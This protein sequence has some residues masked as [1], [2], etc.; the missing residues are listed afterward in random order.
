M[1]NL[2]VI[3]SSNELLTIA[4]RFVLDKSI[5]IKDI[6]KAIIIV[7]K[8]LDRTIKQITTAANNCNA[9]TNCFYSPNS[10]FNLNYLSQLRKDELNYNDIL[11]ALYEKRNILIQANQK[12]ENTSIKEDEPGDK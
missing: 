8:K 12:D 2:N 9:S 3:V 7:S 10:A 11:S 1:E 4:N 6:D 5:T